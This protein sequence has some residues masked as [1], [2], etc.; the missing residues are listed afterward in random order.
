MRLTRIRIA[1]H[2]V[3]NDV[4]YEEIGFSQSATLEVVSSRIRERLAD[5][6][7]PPELLK[8]KQAAFQLQFVS[9]GRLRPRT[10]TFSV[11]SPN[12][13]DLKSKPDELRAIGERCLKMWGISRD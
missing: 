11:S 2:D 3:V 13:C 9:D 7:M 12:A 10:M 8:V 6:G 5:Q 4:R 1:P